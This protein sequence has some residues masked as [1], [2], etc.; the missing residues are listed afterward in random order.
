MSAPAAPGRR[1][2]EGLERGAIL[3]QRCRSCAATVF[4]PRVL[5]PG[6]GAP[7]LE[8]HESSGRG[9]VHAVTTLHRRDEEPYSIAL[10]DCEESFRMMVRLTGFPD[11]DRGAIGAAVVLR[12]ERVVSAPTPVAHPASR[13][14]D[15]G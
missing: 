11:D 9:V 8:W 10:V 12:V 6:C 14:G 15:D 13:D 5:C 4:P 1:Y 7:E 3:H 2:A